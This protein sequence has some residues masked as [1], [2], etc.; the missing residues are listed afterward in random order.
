MQEIL[1]IASYIVFPFIIFIIFSKKIQIIWKIFFILLSLLF[2][3]SRFIE[4]QII[5]IKN[6]IINVWFESNIVLISD[7]HLWIYKDEK[8]IKRVVEKINSLSN[9]DYIFIAWDLTWNPKKEN[10]S[11]LFQPLSEL[12]S[13]TYWVLWN[14]DVEKPGPKIRDELIDILDWYWLHHLNNETI[15]LNNFS[16][17]WLWSNWNNE[18]DV[19]LLQNYNKSDNVIVLTHNPDTISKYTNNISDL[20]LAWHTHWWQVRIPVIYKDVIPTEWIFDK[21]FT[22]ED[23]T[24]LFI[25]S[26]LWESTIPMRIFNPPVINILELK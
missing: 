6:D 10:L 26:W 20:T 3:Y 25:S 21:W 4:T 22:Q 15:E 18:D 12:N 16:L 19:T 11:Q 24:A 8:F 2:I 14:H 7:L 13:P 5:T 9:I 1:F 17:I 23:T